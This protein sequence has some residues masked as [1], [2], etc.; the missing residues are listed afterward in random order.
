MSRTKDYINITMTIHVYKYN[1]PKLYL[2]SI[3]HF[4]SPKLKYPNIVSDIKT[5]YEKD[6]NIF[7]KL[8]HHNNTIQLYNVTIRL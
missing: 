6:Y 8:F 5:T 2:F 1:L 4:L 3:Y 7:N